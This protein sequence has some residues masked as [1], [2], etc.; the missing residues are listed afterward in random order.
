MKKKIFLLILGLYSLYIHAQAVDTNDSLALV[1]FYNSTNG[2]DWLTN[3]NWLTGPVNTWYGITVTG[4]RVTGIKLND[5]DISGTLPSEFWDLTALT[6]IQLSLNDISGVISPA[7]K[8]LTSLISISLT[9]NEIS[10]NIPKEI[11]DLT[12]LTTLQLQINN[13]SGTIPKEIGNLTNLYIID[14]HSNSELG[15]TIPSDMFKS[16]TSLNSIDLSSCNFTGTLPSTIGDLPNLKTLRVSQNQLH[17]PLPDLTGKALS[18]I[19]ISYNNFTFEAVEAGYLYAPSYYYYT[20]Q[21][22]FPL[23]N[24]TIFFQLGSDTIVDITALSE[25][26]LGGSNNLYQWYKGSSAV[27]SVS[28]DPVLSF[29]EISTDDY[30]SYTCRV[31]NSVVTDITIIS[32]P[33][34]VAWA[35]SAPSV[36][37]PVAD[38]MVNEGFSGFNIEIDD[39]FSDIDGDEISYSA[40]SDNEAVVIVSIDENVLNVTESGTG[41]AKITIT[42]NDVN[43]GVSEH[44]FNIKVNASPTVVYPVSDT[45]VN[46]GFGYITLNIDTVFTDADGDNLTYE[47][48]SENTEIVSVN[49][50]NDTLIITETGTGITKITITASDGYE[51]SVN[52]EFNVR[53]NTSPEVGNPLT[54]TTVNEGFISFNI[55]LDNVFTDND[56]DELSYSAVSDNEDVVTVSISSN[57]LTVTESDTGTAKITITANDGYNGISEHEF[58]VSVNSVPTIVN[59]V[60]DTIVNEGFGYITISIDSV[61]TDADGDSLIYSVVSEN[62][63][64]VSV[65]M[66]N[67]TLTITENGTGTTKITITANDGKGAIVNDE[68][69]VRVNPPP[70]INVPLADTAVNEGFTSFSID[71]DNVFTDIDGDE[72]SFSAVSDNEGVVTVSISSNI[73][74]V[75]ES[76]IGTANIT[77]TANDEFGMI[78][79]DEFDILVNVIPAAINPVSDTLVNEGFGS[80]D[81]DISNVFTDADGDTLSLDAVS[82]NTDAALVSINEDILRINENGTGTANITVT[83]NDGNGGY[84]TNEFNIIINAIPKVANPVSDINVSEGF[85]GTT[86]DISETFSDNDGDELSFTVS[87]DNTGIATVSI[88]GNTLTITEAGT[89]SAHITLTAND[90]VGG[91]V[92]DIFTININEAGNIAPV[93]INPLADQVA[94]EGFTSLM[95][96]LDNVFTDTD[97]DALSYYAVSGNT[98]VVNTYIAGG[99]LVISE[100]GA[101]TAVITITAND[102]KGG[103]VND[104][105]VINVNAA[106]NNIPVVVNPV[107]DI[108]RNKGFTSIAVD[109][110]NIFNDT[111]GDNLSYGVVSSDTGV[112]KVN[113]MADTLY[114]LENGTGIST[115]M[116]SVNDGKGGAATDE[117]NL[118][119]NSVPTIIDHITDTTVNEGFGNI[120]IDLSVVFTDSDGDNLSYTAVSSKTEVVSVNIT[121]STLSI[122]ETGTGSAR[123]TVTAEDGKGGTIQE[124]FKVKVIESN[125]VEL[126]AKSLT[127]IYIVQVHDQIYFKNIPEGATD[128]LIYDIS[129]KAVIIKENVRENDIINISNLNKGIYIYKLMIKDKAECGKFLIK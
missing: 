121:N 27:T 9:A 32:E 43:N 114:L 111:D 11:G 35:N 47:A 94:D 1:A 98:N 101:G 90:G 117:F 73:L 92:N 57:L 83:A 65:S 86:I 96:G 22:K 87:S 60:S 93:V 63:E 56:G 30:G 3:T 99:T 59:P 23:I 75:T 68:F 108:T 109:L 122:T 39:I 7:I 89:G 103:A 36:V 124:V 31:T 120:S 102:G 112:T 110:T 21:S 44:E 6:N 41:T 115:I 104:V 20:Y 127:K 100:A 105:F 116:I 81:I 97:G 14:L 5:N 74:T 113:I 13:L 76:G 129:G 118:V 62:T 45:I 125:F 29:P 123:I 79:I 67:D 107:A 24:D 54:D 17:G 119:I 28:S 53:V 2:D 25:Y 91:S 95:L 4:T 10:G 126:T 18:V 49:I 85:S 82:D 33:I 66:K 64:I 58:H 8:D 71:M 80:I 16:T 78:V 12:N 46:V 51:A 26:N 128:L 77:V 37:N 88:N 38:T 55:D 72:L 69:S 48:V 61:F 42:A 50:V 15:D 106:G 19:A 34:I 52:N 70:V 84:I 40:V